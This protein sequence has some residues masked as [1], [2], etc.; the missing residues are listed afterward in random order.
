[1]KEI[2]MTDGVE[3]SSYK[4]EWYTLKNKNKKQAY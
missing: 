2:A 1:M 3:T 4:R